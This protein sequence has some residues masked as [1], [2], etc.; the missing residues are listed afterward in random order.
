M[1]RSFKNQF[2]ICAI[3]VAV[4]AANPANAAVTIGG[5]GAGTTLTTSGTSGGSSVVAFNGFVG[6]PAGVIAG[7]T[8]K[9]TL[10]F[11]SI[12]SN[13]IG[14]NTFNFGYTL[15]NNASASVT[16]SRISRFGFDVNPDVTSASSTGVYDFADMGGNQPNNVGTVEVCFKDTSNAGCTGGPGGL[17]LGQSGSGTLS[18]A[19]NSN[20]T[21]ITLSNFFTRYQSLDAR[22]IEGGSA[23]GQVTTPSSPVPEPAAWMLM[24]VGFGAIGFAMRKKRYT[25]TARV[26]FV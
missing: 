18:L 11:V 19:F 5:S 26:R 15:D 1:S 17:T 10:S 7:L 21:A 16:A 25:Q 3:A 6:S 2:A 22:G 12:T 8:A 4:V 14:G 24:L 23:S 9:L 20:Q 13:M